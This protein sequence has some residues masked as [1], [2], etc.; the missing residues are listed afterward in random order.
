VTHVGIWRRPTEDVYLSFA[1]VE[2]SK[3]VI[4]AYVFPLVSWIW[5]GIF[6]LLF[7]TIICMIPSKSR[8]ARRREPLAEPVRPAVQEAELAQ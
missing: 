2:D 8:E 5:I 7:G 4:Q 1:G 6:V 3:A